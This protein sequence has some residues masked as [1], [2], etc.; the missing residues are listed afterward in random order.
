MNKIIRWMIAF[1]LL[2]AV[3]LAACDFPIQAGLSASDVGGSDAL[4]AQS[5]SSPSEAEVSDGLPALADSSDFNY[6]GTVKPPPPDAEGC[7]PGDYP[8]G[9]VAVIKASAMPSEYCLAGNL[10]PPF[11][12][13]RLPDGAGEFLGDVVFVRYFKQGSLQYELPSESSEVQICFAVP[14]GSLP[15]IYF[16]DFYG[17]HFGTRTGQ[18]DWELVDTIIED[19]VACAPA[20]TSGA[21]GLVSQ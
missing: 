15:Q 16:Y 5:D 6:Q 8:L 11:A 3:L 18:P 12:M 13:G 1:G 19:E 9:G 10:R 20:L 21:Y 7:E 14:P 2:M 4:P 17:P